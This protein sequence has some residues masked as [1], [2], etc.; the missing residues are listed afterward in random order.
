MNVEL[1][2]ILKQINDLQ[3][4][5]LDVMS[6]HQVLPEELPSERTLEEVPEHEAPAPDTRIAWSGGVPPTIQEE[7]EAAYGFKYQ[8]DV[9]GVAYRKGAW[10]RE[11]AWESAQRV[12]RF[13][14]WRGRVPAVPYNCLRK[15]HTENW[16]VWIY[17]KSLLKNSKWLQQK[18]IDRRQE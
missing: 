8:I 5:V 4:A 7:F 2:R 10:T 1:V 14:R 17:D 18:I 9:P 3:A 15:R 16:Y 11:G 13:L 12:W 6:R